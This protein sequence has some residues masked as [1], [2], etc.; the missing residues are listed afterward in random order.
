[1]VPS[2]RFPS[3]RAVVFDLDGTLI[4][5]A[6]DITLAM[7]RVLADHGRRPL[8]TAETRSMLGDGAREL[9]RQ[10]FAVTGSA[11]PE[12]EVPAVLA[13]YLD[14]YAAVPADPSC[15]YPGVFET[16]DR[17]AEAR[18]VLALCTN[19]AE[20]ITTLVLNQLG[21][22]GRFQVVL[23]GDTLP[24]RKPDPRVLGWVMDRLELPPAAAVMVGDG[25]N[26]VA[27]AHALGMPAVAVSY[28]YP[29]MALA[30]LG[31]DVIIDR[32]PD[33][34]ELVVAPSAVR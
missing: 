4:D 9:V 12:A 24:Q 28:G 27:S 26:D 25:R 29:R 31:A 13:Q 15:L 1:M 32:L 22:G 3:C 33:L 16:L 14:A 6:A 8:T 18:L 2:I 7:N 10:V 19:K 11:L 5:S 34:V 23:G 17:L 20:R 21:L 30:D